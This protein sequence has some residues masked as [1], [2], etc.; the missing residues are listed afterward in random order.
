MTLFS[1]SSS[2]NHR[3]CRAVPKAGWRCRASSATGGGQG[4]LAVPGEL[5]VVGRPRRHWKGKARRASMGRHLPR[6][7]LSAAPRCCSATRPTAAKPP[8]TSVRD[9]ASPR[10]PVPRSLGRKGGI[11]GQARSDGD[12]QGRH[13]SAAQIKVKQR[14]ASPV[15]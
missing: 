14:R 10:L 1:V 13:R 8:A 7:A 12:G 6:V 4:G 5:E 9:S 15:T 2:S 3:R 11:E